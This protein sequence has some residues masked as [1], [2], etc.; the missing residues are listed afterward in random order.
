MVDQVAESALLE[1]IEVDVGPVGRVE[2]GSGDTE[3]GG[4]CKQVHDFSCFLAI[5]ILSNR[6]YSM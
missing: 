6:N 3:D 5:I 4:N 1:F 2:S